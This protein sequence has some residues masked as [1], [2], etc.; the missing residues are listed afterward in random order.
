MSAQ[1][2][3]YHHQLG[4]VETDEEQKSKKKK[5]FLRRQISLEP[6]C[7]TSF[8]HMA[9]SFIQLSFQMNGPRAP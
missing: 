8:G 3:K 2:T 6:F 9:I 7:R 1:K 4:E 5:C